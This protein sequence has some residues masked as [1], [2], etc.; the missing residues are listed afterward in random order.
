MN[1][2]TL[3]PKPYTLNPIPYTLNPIS[4]TLYPKLNPKLEERKMI[5]A[6][7]SVRFPLSQNIIHALK[8][9][10]AVLASKN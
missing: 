3:N 7:P 9:L 2:D 8:Y 5:W 1:H 4:Y 6:N 10:T